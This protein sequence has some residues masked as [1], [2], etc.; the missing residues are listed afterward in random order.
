[1]LVYVYIFVFICIY[2]FMCVCVYI[3][4]KEKARGFF[5]SIIMLFCVLSFNQIVCQIN[6]KYSD[7]DNRNQYMYITISDNKTS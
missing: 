7:N 6:N 4:P 3:F 1:M 2:V 5:T